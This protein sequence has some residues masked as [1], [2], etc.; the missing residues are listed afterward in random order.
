MTSKQIATYLDRHDDFGVMLG[1]ALVA[2]YPG[3]P[4][5]HTTTP[6]VLVAKDL[7]CLEELSAL[8]WCID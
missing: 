8:G 2:L 7:G 5:R 1:S 4:E 6:T 3:H